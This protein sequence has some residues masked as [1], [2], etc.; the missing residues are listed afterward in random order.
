MSIA[1]AVTKGGRTVLAT[2]TQDNFG[3][4]RFADANHHATKMLKVGSSWIATTG[5][6]LYENIFEDY[7]ARSRPP[8]LTTKAAV[9]AFFL[10]FWKALEDRYSLVNN[11]SNRDD[12]TPFAD[13]DA[14]FL[15]V[16][17]RGIFHVCGNMSVSEFSEY[18]A[19]GSGA[20]YALGALHVL[21]GGRGGAEAIA[22]T[23]CESA[24][25][26]DLYCGGAV[27]VQNV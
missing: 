7:L 19:I 15:I 13:L 12:H 3:D 6:G 17:R 23:A 9:F 5:W 16:N 27:E 20:S 10:R 25:A 18:Y 4:R 21:H 14:S 24:I 26:F 8:R 11:Q 2:D 1:V 22:R